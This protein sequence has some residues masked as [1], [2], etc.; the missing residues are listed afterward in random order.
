M[1]TYLQTNYYTVQGITRKS[2]L[3][4]YLYAQN[5]QNINK[6]NY[7]FQYLAA[8]IDLKLDYIL[9]K[10]VKISRMDAADYRK[11]STTS[12]T[13]DVE[14]EPVNFPFPVTTKDDL[15]NLELRIREDIVFKKKLV[16]IGDNKCICRNY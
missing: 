8:L 6:K 3:L 15:E 11:V 9:N 5:F 1:Y 7:F 12:S 16:L 2:K 13:T 10:I 4:T 14:P